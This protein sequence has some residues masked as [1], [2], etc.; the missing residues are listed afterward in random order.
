MH[1]L[2]LKSNRLVDMVKMTKEEGR[3]NMEEG[4][5]N[6]VEAMRNKE[7]EDRTKGKRRGKRWRKKSS[8]KK[9]PKNTSI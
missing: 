1:K 4:M 8:S 5:R 2:V 3:R 6:E 7:V 9:R